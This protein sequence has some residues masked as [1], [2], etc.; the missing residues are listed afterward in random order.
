MNNLETIKQELINQK[1]KLDSVGYTVNVANTNP[2]PTEITT[3][4][5]EIPDM[6]LANATP[7]DVAEGKTFYAG[8]NSLHTGVMPSTLD[9]VNKND[10]AI[11]LQGQAGGT[12][13]SAN[14][15]IG[16]T[17]IRSYC[18]FENV[19]SDILKGHVTI[20]E[21]VV[22]IGRYGLASTNFESISFP[23]TLKTLESYSL[24]YCVKLKEVVIPEAITTL[25]SNT[26][27][28]T[29]N[30]E[31]I[32]FPSKLTSIQEGNFHANNKLTTIT[33]PSTLTHIYHNNFNV[34]PEL[35]EIILLGN[36]T[37][38]IYSGN[39]KTVHADLII[40]CNFE[41]LESYI[42]KTNWV[43]HIPRFICKYNLSAGESFPTPT[44][45]ANSFVWF[46]N[47]ADAVA[48]TNPITEPLGEGLYYVRIQTE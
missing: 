17:R 43:Q 12:F 19:Q 40:W 22:S 45:S 39:L 9:E 6:R 26:F 32:T 5:Q 35:R 24:S 44:D 4:M 47:E 37:K 34:N 11:L 3:A 15:P 7:L 42:T 48:R 8:D 30:L 23:S 27:N 20:P 18:F 36:D 1:T 28:S 10:V 21:G 29:T 2:S 14:F 41:A 33:F 13:D 46:A 38:F 16:I 31:K 25:S